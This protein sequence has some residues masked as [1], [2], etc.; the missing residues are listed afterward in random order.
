[1]TDGGGTMGSGGGSRSDGN[2]LLFTLLGCA[3]LCLLGLCVSTGVAAYM[4]VRDRDALLATP[5]DP[6]AV[7][8]SGKP[9]SQGGGDLPAPPTP[10]PSLPRLRVAAAVAS[11]T[12]NVVPNGA[13]C[14]F[15][16][17]PPADAQ[18]NCRAQIVCGGQLVYGGQSAGY[19]PCRVSGGT[20][21]SIA[22]RDGQTTST[23]GDGAMAIDTAARTLVVRDDDRGPHG[24]FALEARIESVE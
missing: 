23:D 2:G 7:D 17:E 6:G 20:R 8:P 13:R 24:A 16:V 3:G 1:M 12:G 4:V 22:G 10:G 5:G 14:L 11:V 15:D 18:S 9:P 19:F 21:P